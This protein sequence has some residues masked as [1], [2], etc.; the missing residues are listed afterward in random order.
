M[1]QMSDDREKELQQ[2]LAGC[3]LDS[4][5][6]YCVAG[7]ALAIPIGVRLNSYNPLVYLGLSGTLLDL[8]NGELDPGASRPGGE[9]SVA[10]T[11]IIS[12]HPSGPLVQSRRLQQ[13]HEGEG[14]VAGLPARG[15]H[16]PTVALGSHVV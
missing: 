11:C 12:A 3:V 4:S 7:V 13:V 14:G 1:A 8:L 9:D 6:F 15:G 16:T 10:C 2:A 5:W